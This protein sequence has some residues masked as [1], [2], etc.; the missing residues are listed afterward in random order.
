MGLLSETLSCAGSGHYRGEGNTTSSPSLDR[1]ASLEEGRAGSSPSKS[2]FS[3]EQ[4]SAGAGQGSGTFSQGACL[5]HSN[6]SGVGKK[7]FSEECTIVA[8]K[9][10][11][12]P[13]PLTGRP[14]E[15]CIRL[16][17]DLPGI[18]NF[19]CVQR[20]RRTFRSYMSDGA[21]TALKSAQLP[22]FRAMQHCL[23]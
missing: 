12:R 10:E 19:L 7:V 9:L 8:E 21:R 20:N 3:I 18:R 16:V 17:F 4:P 15:A 14:L 22:G 5:V 11:C 2:T 13:V 6:L 1:A 23:S